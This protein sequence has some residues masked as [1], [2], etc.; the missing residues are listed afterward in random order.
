MVRAPLFFDAGCSSHFET[1]L[2]VA[3]GKLGSCNDTCLT[4]GLQ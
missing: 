2:L 4:G 1:H 3:N